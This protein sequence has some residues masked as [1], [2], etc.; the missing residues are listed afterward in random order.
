MKIWA[1]LVYS[2]NNEIDRNVFWDAGEMAQRLRVV[3]VFAEDQSLVPNTQDRRLK[4]TCNFRPHDSTCFSS[5]CVYL[6][7]SAPPQTNKKL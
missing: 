3:A 6:R 2:L 1:E 4:I 7:T 5:F